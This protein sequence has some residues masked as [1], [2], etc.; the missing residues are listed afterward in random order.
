MSS[1][2]NRSQQPQVRDVC[3]FVFLVL[4]IWHDA[5]VKKQPEQATIMPVTFSLIR[6]A[7]VVANNRGANNDNPLGACEETAQQH[8]RRPER[9][10]T[11][12]LVIFLLRHETFV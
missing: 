6:K 7:E 12:A 2:S 4:I 5:E 9:F 10:V 1:R 3:S 8:L 11:I